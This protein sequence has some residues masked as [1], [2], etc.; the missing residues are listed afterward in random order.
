M[1]HFAAIR[2]ILEKN[3]LDAMMLTEEFNRFYAAD[4][5]SIGTDALALVTKRGAYYFT[6]SRYTVAAEEQ[7]RDAEIGLVTRERSYPVWVNEV[8]RKESLRAVGFDDAYMTVADWRKYR[9][10]L[11]CE[12]VPASEL[13]RELR[14]VKD[15]EEERRLI[16]AQ[17]I[18]EQALSEVMALLRPGLTE[19]AV[20]AEL[21][22]RMLLHGA[23]KMSFDPIVVSGARGAMPHG[24]PS[25][26]VIERGEFVTMDFGCMFRGYCSDMTRTVAVGS[27]TEEMRRVYGVVLA[28]QKAG[29]AATRAGRTGREIDGVARKIIE[30][31]GYGEYFGHSYGH[32][33]GVEIHE[34]PGLGPGGDKPLPAGAAASAEP[35]IYLP[36]K[37]GVRIEDVV[38]IREDGCEDIA[39][40]P[41]ELIVV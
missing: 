37:F 10:K 4:F 13:L 36:G 19:K 7:V 14:T 22:Y 26:K 18:S 31:A 41:K 2:A 1:N 17:R 28:A 39:L 5:P 11:E 23:E 38:L 32:G 6:D 34:G 33:V 21:Q 16:A 35:G 27:A 3:D 24:L 40:A 29:I 8:I 30:D 9:E 25:D 15:P 20:A 12:L